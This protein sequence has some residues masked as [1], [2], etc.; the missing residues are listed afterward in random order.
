MG[1]LERAAARYRPTRTTTLATVGAKA[2]SEPPFWASDALAGPWAGIRASTPDRE[3]LDVSFEAY[4]CEL[5]KKNGVIFS[6]I[7]RRQQVFSQARFQWQRWKN[8]RP[9]DMYG[10]PGLRLLEKPWMNGTTGELLSRLEVD[11]SAC[12]NSYWTTCDDRGRLGRAA[13]IDDNRRLVRLRPDWVTLIIGGPSDDPYAPDAR[14]L[15][16]SYLPM[17]T[18]GY[19]AQVYRE[20]IIFLP[21]EVCHYSPK[22]DPV[23]RFLGMS[24][25][26]PIIHDIFADQ[27]AAT[28]KMKFFQN[29]ANPSLA[30]T[31]DKEVPPKDLD[32]YKKKFDDMHAGVENSFKTLFMGG[33]AD[34][35]PLTVDLRQL[36]FKVTTG[37]GETRM[38]VASGV[39]AVILGISEGLGGSSLNEGNFRAAKRLFVDGTIQDL[40]RKVAPS[41]EVLLTPPGDGSE[42]TIDGRDIPFLREDADSQAAIR[43][44]DAQT[45]RTLGDGGWEPESILL[46]MATSDVSRLVHSGMVPVQLQPPGAP[47]APPALPAA[48]PAPMTEGP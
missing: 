5:Y 17:P 48:A 38:A 32:L 6:A 14:V 21:N 7:D 39:P 27:A 23:A 35:T 11:S 3:N 29:G 43:T 9:Q 31:F 19:G 2:F 25:I 18:A 22:P 12:G 26:T 24:W 16:Y 40:W 20:P 45:I 37:A 41:L 4:C 1:I 8:G 34:L 13:R 46:Y 33:G 44:Q 15:A 10:N 47:T 30:V 42:L 28:H 36:D